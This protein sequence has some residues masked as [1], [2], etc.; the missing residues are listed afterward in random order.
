MNLIR[1]ASE[2][3]INPIIK[4]LIYGQSGIGKTTL[5]LSASNKTLLFDFDGGINRVDYALIGETMTV[6]V[7]SYQDFL[8]V[9]ASPEINE[10]DSF[11]FDTGGKMLDYMG[12][13]IIANN[14]KMKTSNGSLSLK[15]YQERKTIFVQLIRRLST[16]NKNLIFVAQRESRTEGEETRYI[17]QFGGSNYDAIVT[18][19]DVVGYV[20]AQGRKRTITFDPTS[21]SDGKNTCNLPSIIEIP[22]LIDEQGNKI[23]ENDFLKKYVINTFIER[24]KARKEQGIAFEKLM[25]DI[26]EQIELV[27]DD[28]SVNEFVGRINEFDHKQNSLELAK[29]KLHNKAISLG[30]TFD[31]TKKKYV[32]AKKE[33]AKVETEE[34][35]E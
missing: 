25:N 7:K 5:A 20:E 17:P 24:M 8:D 14:Y 3:E 11:V 34:K 6:Q 28:K 23:K 9:I 33:T 2:L 15:G 22:L 32:L 27:T 19:L 1:K 26:Y 13:Y 18:E 4:M 16:M 30:C 10:F 21:R 35:S 31:R 12:E 29:R